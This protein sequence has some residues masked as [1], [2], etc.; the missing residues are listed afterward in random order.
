MLLVGKRLVLPR[1]RGILSVLF[2]PLTPSQMSMLEG[3]KGC[4]TRRL[5]SSLSYALSYSF[6]ISFLVVQLVACM[7]VCRYKTFSLDS[8]W[9][10]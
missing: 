10:A 6:F 5:I 4:L 3:S 2:M 8:T 9:P 7:N 1:G